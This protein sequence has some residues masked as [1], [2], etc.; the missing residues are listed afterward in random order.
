MALFKAGNTALPANYKPISLLAVGYKVVAGLLLDRLRS[1]GVEERLRTSQFGYRAGR[2]TQDA[3]F[4][5]K[6]IVETCLSQQDNQ[7]SMV[8]LDWSRAFDKI[9]PEAMLQALHRFGLPKEILEMVAAIYAT[10]TFCIK[11]AGVVSSERRQSCGIVQGCPLSPYLFIMVLTVVFADTDL[12]TDNHPLSL[13]ESIPSTLDITYAD[14]TL[15]VSMDPLRL[16]CF[17]TTLTEVAETYGL[18]PNL[19]KTK[20][21]RIGH[22]ED[23]TVSGVTL[24]VVQ[25]AVYLGS[26]ITSS[27]LAA[28]SLARRIGEARRTFETLDAVWKHA[29]MTRHRKVMLYRSCILAR[30]A[31]SM[32]C[33]TLRAADYSR[34]DAFNCRRLRKFLGIPHSMISRVSNREVLSQAGLPAFSRKIKER[35]LLLFGRLAMMPSSSCVRLAALDPYTPAPK[36]M[37][38]RRRRGRP[39]LAWNTIVY[40][41]ALQICNGNQQ[42]LN[43]RLPCVGGDFLAWRKLVEDQ[44]PFSL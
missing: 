41:I 27:G 9:L 24:E 36:Q 14:D 4:M 38:A 7:L 44:A 43:E 31:Y 6:R 18:K 28:P 34:L 32:E 16:Q 15:L 17:L 37:I 42:H 21:M 19:A 12:A 26:L 35:Q 30:L 22:S 1:G 3:I 33:E 8:F 13:L 39:R 40:A 10:R 2:S 29:N 5:A 11:E 25:Q 23:V 20:H